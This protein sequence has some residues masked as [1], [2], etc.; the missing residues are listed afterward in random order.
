MH[1]SL[2]QGSRFAYRAGTADEVITL[3]AGAQLWL[4]SCRAPAGTPAT[5]T[6]APGG[7]N[8]VAGPVTGDTI[9]LLAGC[10]FSQDFL[11]V[12][13]TGTVITMVGIGSFY[14]SWFLPRTGAAAS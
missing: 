4:V 14:I 9:T 13:G 10:G 1:L 7:A 8:Q 12:L 3:P 2:I 6:I 5:L 11:G